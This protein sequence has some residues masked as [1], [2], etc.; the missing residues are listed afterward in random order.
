MSQEFSSNISKTTAYVSGTPSRIP[1]WL[2]L[3]YTGFLA[4]LIPYYWVS[5]GPTN[6]LYFCDVALF[7]TLIAVWTEKPLFASMAAVGIILP[8]AVWVL[9]F[10]FGLIGMPLLGMTEYMF[11]DSLS[12][13]T[14]GLSLFHGWLPFLLIYLVYKLR[15]DARALLYWTVLAWGLLVICYWFMPAPGETLANPNAPRNINYVYGFSE[16]TAQTWMSANAW[17]T[18]L[19]LALPACIYFPTHKM[20]ERLFGKKEKAI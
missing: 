19:L 11:R 4:I 12:L 7:L 9:D 20:L 8:Q 15:Y 6:F 18:F 1:L 13:F 3:V 16:E 10:A 5:Y 17:F 2:K 14:R